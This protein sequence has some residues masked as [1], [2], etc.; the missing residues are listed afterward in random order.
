MKP[1]LSDLAEE[2]RL[3]GDLVASLVD[4]SVL[5]AASAETRRPRY[6]MPAPRH[7]PLIE[8]E[9]RRALAAGA[10]ARCPVCGSLVPSVESGK[11]CPECL[12]RW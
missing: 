6:R 9:R 1:T 7:V 12:S 3:L 8:A 10:A 2:N 5:Y 4:D 11:E